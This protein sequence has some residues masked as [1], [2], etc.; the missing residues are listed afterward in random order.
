[1]TMAAAV[2]TEDR[3]FAP[4]LG[5]LARQIVDAVCNNPSMSRTERTRQLALL[6]RALNAVRGADCRIAALETHIEHL[7]S[8]SR[9][10]FLTGV[11]NRR[12]LDDHVRRVVAAAHR[13]GDTGVLVLIDLDRFKDI[14]DSFGHAA[15]DTVLKH[16]ARVLGANVR[17]SDFVA[18]LGGDEF[19]V[20]LAHTGPA[21]GMCR[22]RRLQATLT[23]SPVDVGQ[24]SL[25]LEASFGS[26]NYGIGTDESDLI[27]CADVAMYRQK[28]SRGL[29][30]TRL[31][32]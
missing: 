12:G 19:A 29:R 4:E 5:H 32:S 26:A 3:P 20:V 28:R 22:A 31:A 21:E 2:L 18:R 17:A 8:L 30:Y 15:G 14:N 13:H 6:E 23:Q 27:R 16:V 1:M 7:E 10:D 9:T 11:A 25:R 24:H